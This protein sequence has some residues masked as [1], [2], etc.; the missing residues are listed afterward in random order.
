LRAFTLTAVLVLSSF[1]LAPYLPTYL[2]GNVGMDKTDLKY[3]YLYGG[4]ATLA[5]MTL[6]GRLADRFGKLRVFR[7][8]ALG[9]V[10]PVALTTNLPHG[11]PLVLVLT[12]T[13]VYWVTASGRWVPAMALVTAS[14]AP[15]YRGSFMSLNAAVQH[16]AAGLAALLGGALLAEEGDGL[17]GF[18]VVGILACV[19]SVASVV[20]A[21]RLRPAPEGLLAPDSAALASEDQAPESESLPASA[22]AVLE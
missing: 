8:L 13:T 3:M 15:A 10:L 1:V 21:G 14:A 2:V 17:A 19:A 16:L 6:F 12:L 7:I 5:T 20:L 11:L 4:L 9:T 18:P 22:G